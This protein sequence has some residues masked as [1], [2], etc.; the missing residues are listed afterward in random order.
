[1]PEVKTWCANCGNSTPMKYKLNDEYLCKECHILRIAE[2]MELFEELMMYFTE[3]K[4]KQD[5]CG[6]VE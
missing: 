6:K 5:N 4:P 1:M 3:K 2:D